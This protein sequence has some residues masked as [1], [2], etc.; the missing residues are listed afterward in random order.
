MIGKRKCVFLLVMII[1]VVAVV[2]F[3]P[4][5]GDEGEKDRDKEEENQ[6]EKNGAKEKKQAYKEKQK[7]VDLEAIECYF[8]GMEEEMAEEYEIFSRPIMVTL[9]NS[10]NERPQSGLSKACVVYELLAEGNITRL[11]ALYNKEVPGEI[12]NVRSARLYFIP[13]ILENDAYYAHVGGHHLA[14][15]KLSEIGVANLNEFDHPGFWRSE[16]TEAPF[17][18]YTSPGDLKASAQSM[19]YR[20]E[21][22][23]EEFA[24]FTEEESISGEKAKKIRISY[25]STNVVDYEY[26]EEKMAYLRS[27]NGQYHLDGIEDE[28]IKASNIIVQYADSRV[29]DDEGRR[30]IEIIGSGEGKFISGGQVSSITWEKES[31]RATTKFY[32]NEGKEIE[33][34]PGQ[35]W[36]NVV[37]GGDSVSIN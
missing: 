10:S 15:S 34:Y 31:M 11:L 17:N 32:D 25:G 27:V 20:K 36:I 30:D 37:P 5:C 13:L 33:L 12:G 8:C 23:R 16:A 7:G 9:G 18:V 35:T 19:G 24:E 22:N 4:G 29:I 6:I 1:T 28:K 3:M 2:I 21:G 26:D 14:L